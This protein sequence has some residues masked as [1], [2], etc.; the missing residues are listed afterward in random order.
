M[1]RLYI[2]KVTGIRKSEIVYHIIQLHHTMQ[3]VN[4]IL[5]HASGRT[6]STTKEPP[7]EH[8]LR[9]QLPQAPS[10]EFRRENGEAR[11]L[12]LR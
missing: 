10:S 5:W 8:P 4:S 3:I 9:P 7:D 1:R 2:K 11:C 12:P 6:G